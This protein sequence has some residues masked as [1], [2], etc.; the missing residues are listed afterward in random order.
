MQFKLIQI[1]AMVAS[2]NSAITQSQQSASGS[3]QGA[4]YNVQAVTNGNA[5]AN[6]T[7]GSASGAVNANFAGAVGNYS[8]SGNV[9][10]DGRASGGIDTNTGIVTGQAA[11][12]IQVV[13]NFNGLPT[14][15][16]A[17]GNILATL[18]ASGNLCFNAAGAV[19]GSAGGNSMTLPLTKNA[20]GVYSG[21]LQIG[22]YVDLNSFAVTLSTVLSQS[23]Y[24][25]ATATTPAHFVSGSTGGPSVVGSGSGG[26]GYGGSQKTSSTANN[27]ST[28]GAQ[29]LA[30]FGGLITIVSVVAGL[31][32][33]IF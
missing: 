16:A 18:D 22:K 8:A 2:F 7:S 21:C 4:S 24:V 15:I 25:P 28:S 27:Q 29:S 10:A 1:F 11:G 31:F 30:A 19:A 32:A 20:N 3:S 23:I 26:S 17:N 14:V 33:M 6:G 5:N 13:A 9:A 12:A